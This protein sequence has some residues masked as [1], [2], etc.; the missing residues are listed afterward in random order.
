MLKSVCFLYSVNYME[1]LII[2]IQTYAL[3]RCGLKKPVVIQTGM[4]GSLFQGAG[5]FVRNVSICL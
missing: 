2:S 5:I 1:V 3:N 4:D